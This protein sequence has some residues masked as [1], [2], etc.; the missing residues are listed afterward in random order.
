MSDVEDITENP[1]FDRGA[2]EEDTPDQSTGSET[3]E[4]ETVQGEDPPQGLKSSPEE[5]GKKKEGPPAASS[6]EDKELTSL[7]SQV[8]EHEDILSEMADKISKQKQEVG[9]IVVNALH[10]A[11]EEVMDE[12]RKEFNPKLARGREQANELGYELYQIRNLTQASRKSLELLQ[13]G[14][15]D[16][17]LKSMIADLRRDMRDRLE[18]AD[19]DVKFLEERMFGKNMRG[20]S[21]FTFIPE[22]PD[23][24]PE[25]RVSF[26][27]ILGEKRGARSG[28]T[29]HPKKEKQKKNGKKGKG[30]ARRSDSSSESSSSDDSLDDSSTDEESSE[31]LDGTYSRA[32]TKT[33]QRTERASH[34]GK[35]KIKVPTIRLDPSVKRHIKEID[36]RPPNTQEHATIKKVGESIAGRIGYFLPP[37]QEAAAKEANTK[38]KYETSASV[39]FD[40]V[41]SDAVTNRKANREVL[42]QVIPAHVIG[43]ANRKI[44][45]GMV[46]GEN[47]NRTVREFREVFLQW[48]EPERDRKDEIS[49][50]WRDPQQKDESP[51][52]FLDRLALAQQL[53]ARSDAEVKERFLSGLRD[54]YRRRVRVLGDLSSEHP[55]IIVKTLLDDEM[56]LKEAQG[57]TDKMDGGPADKGKD[58]QANK[59]QT[60]TVSPNDA[61]EGA[62]VGD[63]IQQLKDTIQELKSGQEVPGGSSKRP[64]PQKLRPG[65]T[66][67]GRPGDRPEKPKWYKTKGEQLCHNCR[68]HYD[69]VHDCPAKDKKCS[70]CGVMGHFARCCPEV[71][72]AILAPLSGVTGNGASAPGRT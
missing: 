25:K 3:R 69:G 12:I 11:K 72:K 56:F 14:T 52:Q 33:G 29:P 20:S 16:E 36:G 46:T 26:E 50:K 55:R 28:G 49:R 54:R 23:G 1:G 27:N 63:L 13:K 59:I 40:L 44:V 19:R 61:G 6:T 39:W 4:E 22:T 66:K 18:R 30:D 17:E 64:P 67:E 32:N 8:W 60:V 24:T 2:S 57:V 7:K 71:A 65:A 35:N 70:D 41:V 53:L 9:Q 68:E 62:P 37:G 51:E 47:R 58:K 43:H 5:P 45:I 42:F 48:Y 31:E 34:E 38:L 10:L 15:Q 21:P